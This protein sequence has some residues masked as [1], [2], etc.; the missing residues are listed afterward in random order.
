MTQPPA[1]SLAF[2]GPVEAEIRP[3]LLHFC[4]E[5]ERHHGHRILS[6]QLRLDV[7]D[8]TSSHPPVVAM[9]EVDSVLAAVSIASRTNEGWTLEVVCQHDH[10][11]APAR[12]IIR[13]VVNGVTDLLQTENPVRITWWARAHDPWVEHI[14]SALGFVE[15]RRLHQMR[16][17]LTTDNA[18]RFHDGAAETRG[19]IVGS[20]EHEWL[21]VNNA[22]FADHEEQGGWTH[23]QL[24]RRVRAPWFLADDL[25]LHPVSGGI[26]GFCWTKRHEPDL[27]EP[28]LGEIYAI[29]VDP[30]Q[31][32]QGLGKQMV[33][34]GFSHLARAGISIGMLYVDADNTAAMALYESIGMEV[35]HT[36][37]AYRWSGP[38]SA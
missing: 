27:H 7:L 22:A 3:A 33:M 16:I 14:A 9:A 34:A 13:L 23:E 24:E 29:A 30:S 37:R 28:E 12:E 21:S 26:T 15:Y 31:V 18:T 5:V 35:H 20:D 25:R 6:D 10:A 4:D 32:G 19:F 8:E 11:L 17:S 2:A 38:P 36:D 1:P